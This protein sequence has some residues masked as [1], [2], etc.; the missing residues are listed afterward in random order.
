MCLIKL[1]ERL[2]TIA[3]L[4]KNGSSVADIGT[5][6][7]YLPIYLALKGM[8]RDIIASDIS[9]EAL[10]AAL[11]NAAKHG[12]GDKITFIAAPGL[13]GVGESEADTIVIAGMGGETIVSI[14]AG[15]PWTKR[16]GV[17]L[18]LQPQTKTGELCEWLCGNGCAIQDAKLARDR[19]RLYV[20]IVAQ[21]TGHRE[22]GSGH[23]AQGTGVREQDTGDREQGTGIREPLPPLQPPLQGEVAHSAGGVDYLSLFA[24]KRPA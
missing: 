13:A 10:K 23:R 14:L 20:V 16:R 3:G 15:A 9:A 19:G 11:Q 4:I 12:V 8:A 18:I 1:P 6:H 21:G 22:Q 17:K 24:T 2:N 5:D 7:G